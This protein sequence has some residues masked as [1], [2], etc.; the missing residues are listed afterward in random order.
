MGVI[1][2]HAPSLLADTGKNLSAQSTSMPYSTLNLLVTR[3]DTDPNTFRKWEA[4]MLEVRVDTTERNTV[5]AACIM[6]LIVLL[7]WNL[8]IARD[9]ISGLKAGGVS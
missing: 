2:E 7:A 9:I 1:V 5:I 8:P 3:S 4:A 6:I